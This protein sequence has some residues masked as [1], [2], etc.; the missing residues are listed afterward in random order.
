MLIL[1]D[2]S[3]EV[4]DTNAFHFNFTEHSNIDSRQSVLMYGYNASDN[5]EFQEYCQDFSRKI[6]FNNWSPCEFAQKREEN[7]YDALK[8]EQYFNEVYTICPYTNRWLNSLNLGRKYKDIFYPFHESLIP[9]SE[10][11]IYDV[12]Y[13]GGIHGQEHLDC[14]EAMLGFNY[15]YCTMT[16]HIN[17]LT[18]RCLPYATNANLLFRDKIKLVSQCKISICYNLVHIAPDHVPTIKSYTNW[19]HNEAFSEVEKWNVMPQFKT[20]VHEA[21][22][23]RTLNLV[24]RDPWNIIEDYYKPDREFIYFD[25]AE[26]LKSKIANISQDWESYAPIVDAAYTKSLNYTTQKFIDKIRSE[27]EIK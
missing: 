27:G 19:K 17:Q 7:G 25:D 16:N 23:S 5:K 21:A 15:R 9:P 11:K 3:A 26:D 10:E 12:I 2:L 20:R 18:Q 22:I 6:Y 24:Q 4:P 1:Q 8:K 14:L 13:H